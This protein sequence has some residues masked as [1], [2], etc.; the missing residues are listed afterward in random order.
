[1]IKVP[2][3]FNKK[4][5]IAQSQNRM[6]SLCIYLAS[7]ILRFFVKWLAFFF[8]AVLEGLGMSDVDD[9]SSVAF[10]DEDNNAAQ[11]DTV[12]RGLQVGYTVILDIVCTV[13][14]MSKFL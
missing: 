9:E 5:C 10:S 13:M 1:M 11:P 2:D 12:K 3:C 4:Y 8:S 6:G 14:Y 7:D